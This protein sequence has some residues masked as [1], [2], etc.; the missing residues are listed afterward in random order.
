MVVAVRIPSTRALRIGAV[1]A[2]YHVGLVPGVLNEVW[3]TLTRRL[4]CSR[5]RVRWM[6]APSSARVAGVDGR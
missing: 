1:S 5:H 2:G 6:N 4:A 3:Q